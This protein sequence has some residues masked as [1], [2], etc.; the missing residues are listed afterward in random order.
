MKIEI[1]N[2]IDGNTFEIP[3]DGHAKGDPGRPNSRRAQIIRTLREKAPDG[4][5]AFFLTKPAQ[6][7]SADGHRMEA[8]E[9]DVW[10]APNGKGADA[11]QRH[12]LLRR[13]RENQKKARPA[14]APLPLAAEMSRAERAAEAKVVTASMVGRGPKTPKTAAEA[15][16]KEPDGGAQ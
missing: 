16:A 4:R 2:V 8:V 12:E 3:D 11:D 9:G 1:R 5:P 10:G 15:T 14:P 7:W 6:S 13:D